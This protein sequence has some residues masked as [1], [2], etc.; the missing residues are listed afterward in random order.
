MK[1]KINFLIISMFIFLISLSF[2][3]AI[4]I[5]SVEIGKLYSGKSGSLS[6]NVK[7]TFGDDVSD[8]SFILNLDNTGF[9]TLGSSQD[10]EDE[11]REGKKESFNFVLKAS[12]NIKPGDY[13]IPY[14]IIYTDW[15]D[16]KITKKGSFGISVGAKTEL[17]YGIETENNV[18]LEKGK[19]SFKMINSGLGDIGF[20][21]VKIISKNGF[22]LLSNNE[23]YIGT[24]DSD[25]FE[26]AS[27]DVLYKNTGASLT[28]Q[29]TYKDFDNNIQ[30]ETIN[31]PVKVYSREK[32]LEL[33]LIKK[34]NKLTYGLVIGLIIVWLV[35]RKLK[36]RNKNHQGG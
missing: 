8:V 20:V 19:I 23:E 2:T 24:I 34:S 32:A 28:A 30:T 22:E 11:I 35:Y 3:S 25:D 13:N 17:S 33:G 27:F 26:L 29:V 12:S 18:A 4:V 7:N 1:N 6:I 21:S 16:E 31:L 36:K 5:N 10:S 9:T 14:E 15:N